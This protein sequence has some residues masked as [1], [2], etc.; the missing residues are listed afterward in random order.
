M[1]NMY[2]NCREMMTNMTNDTCIQMS[3]TTH[4]QQKGESMGQSHKLRIYTMMIEHNSQ[5]QYFTNIKQIN[6]EWF[7]CACIL[8]GFSH[9]LYTSLV[10]DSRQYSKPQV[11]MIFTLAT[12][13][14]MICD[15]RIITTG[16]EVT[17]AAM[18]CA[19]DPNVEGWLKKQQT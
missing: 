1:I 5:L 12:M 19:H 14:M 3:L 16:M 4:D 13:G 17:T 6:K 9:P 8:V 10:R 2:N 15:D 18:L 11:M 7:L